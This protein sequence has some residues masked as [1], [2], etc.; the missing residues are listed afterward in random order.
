[1]SVN[2]RSA[3]LNLGPVGGP[4]W[5]QNMLRTFPGITLEDAL[6]IRKTENE[7]TGAVFRTAVTATGDGF[8]KACFNLPEHLH[9]ALLMSLPNGCIVTE[10]GQSVGKVAISPNDGPDYSIATRTH[11]TITVERLPHDWRF[12]KG[13]SFGNIRSHLEFG[14]WLRENKEQVI[15]DGGYTMPEHLSPTGKEKFVPFNYPEDL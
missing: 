9:P 7:D 11:V 4:V 13:T 15:K 14:R 10:Y 12:D 5:E 8:I 2:V 3:R 6:T 1:M